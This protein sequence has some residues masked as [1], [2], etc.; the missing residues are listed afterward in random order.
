MRA[1]EL[2]ISTRPL[3]TLAGSLVPK[4]SPELA[5]GRSHIC[6]SAAYY[7]ISQTPLLS[8]YSFQKTQGLRTLFPTTTENALFP[9]LVID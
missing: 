2:L 7:D 9:T 5:D 4:E 3:V 8:S 1:Q 6:T